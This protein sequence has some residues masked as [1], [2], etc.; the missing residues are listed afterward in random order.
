MLLVE[1]MDKEIV[2]AV[3]DDYL[4]QL[5]AQNSTSQ[6]LRSPY[7][8]QDVD[9]FFRLVG[10]A[11]TA[12]QRAEGVQNPI[13]YTE[14]TPEADD[15]ITGEVISYSLRQRKPG[16]FEQ[17]GQGSAMGNRKTRARKK[18]FREAFD[19]PDHAGLKIYTFGKEFDN[20]VE[21]KLHARTNKTANARAMWFENFMEEY[22]WYFRASGVKL[23]TYEGRDKDIHISP[24]NRKLV[25]R[26]LLFYVRTEQV[27]TVKEYNLRSLIV[28]TSI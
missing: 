1:L 8:A 27:T 9:G 16:H 20:I 28:G 10:Q 13:V 5:A 2:L 15:N 22:T 21:F 3:I 23:V 6:K 18:I 19:D 17:G 11:L 4:E 14:D 12:A 26:P 7:P 24:E 25:C